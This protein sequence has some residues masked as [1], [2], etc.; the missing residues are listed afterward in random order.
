[1]SYIEKAQQRA[2]RRKSKW[3]LLLIPGVLIPLAAIWYLSF[4]LMEFV[5]GI[6]YIGQN[7]TDTPRGIGPIIAAVAPLFG[8]L[9]VSF[10]LGNIL[11]WFVSPARR[12]LDSEAAKVPGTSFVESQEDLLKL[13]YVLVPISYG[14]AFIGA[15][16]PWYK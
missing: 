15:L 9:P 16:L 6:I 13:A 3:N 8:T 5:H 4:Q 7:F 1:M 2:K 12:V 14:L 11:V 10:L